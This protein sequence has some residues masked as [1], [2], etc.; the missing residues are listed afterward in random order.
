MGLIDEV[1]K[2]RDPW[3]KRFEEQRQ[4]DYGSEQD[5]DGSSDMEN[6]KRIEENKRRVGKFDR[7]DDRN[8][9]K[10]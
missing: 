3:T 2:R 7:L 1:R 10:R 9:R 6:Q 4:D 5:E 8:V